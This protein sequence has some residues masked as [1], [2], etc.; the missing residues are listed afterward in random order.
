MLANNPS[1]QTKRIERDFSNI[2]KYKQ[3]KSIK[4]L[5]VKNKQVLVR[6]DYNVPLDENNKITDSRRIENTIPTLNYL[7]DQNC[8][9]VLISHL[10]RPGGKVVEELRMNPVFEKLKEYFPNRNVQKIDDCIGE[11][12]ERVAKNLKPKEILL[13]ENP[14]FYI[15]EKKNDLDFAEK[16]ARL[17]DVYVDD[18]FATAH[19]KQASTHGVCSFFDEK[20]YGFLVEKELDFLTSCIENPK[21]PFTVILG[22][23]KVEDKLAVIKYLV[24]LADNIIIGGGMVYTFILAS[25]HQIG[26]SVKDLTKVDEIKGHIE[27][28]SHTTKIFVPIDVVVCD[29][30]ENPKKIKTVSIEQI[31]E[32]DIGV[33]IGPATIASIKNILAD[34]KQVIW[35]GPMGVF[36]K[37]EFEKGT[38]E[39]AEF[40]VNNQIFTVIGGGDS[41]AAI[42]KFNLEDGVTFISTGG[43]ASLEIMKGALLPAIDCLSDK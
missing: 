43:G 19:R 9:I 33:D 21:R 7:L 4:D 35:N 2:L 3:K 10:G 40:L 12:V 25:G 15:E 17:A 28:D 38:K 18:A 11:E 6:V 42:E 31:G 13:L 14:R 20:G 32:D 5:D 30:I 37:K 24:D 34:S 26:K 39:I 41:A 36:E 1:K 27:D 23:K 29:E 22:G 16:L 8:S